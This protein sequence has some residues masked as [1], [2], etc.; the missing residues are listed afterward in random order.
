MTRYQVEEAPPSMERLISEDLRSGDENFLE[1]ALFQLWTMV[2]DDNWAAAE[3]NQ[4]PAGLLVSRWTPCRGASM[5]IQLNG[6][7][8]ITGSP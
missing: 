7:R 2:L 1:Q 8:L 3:K 4:E 5:G 6:I